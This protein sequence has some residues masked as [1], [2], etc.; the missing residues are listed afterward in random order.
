PVLNKPFQLADLQGALS[1][2]LDKRAA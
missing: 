1:R 2:A